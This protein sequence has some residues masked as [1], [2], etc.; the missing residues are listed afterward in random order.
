MT[1]L[2][3]LKSMKLHEEITTNIWDVKRTLTGFL[4]KYLNG[5]VAFE[6]VDFPPAD[7]TLIHGNPVDKE[8]LDKENKE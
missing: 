6:K 2:E 5:N 7:I 4:Y 3:K 1:E 8:T